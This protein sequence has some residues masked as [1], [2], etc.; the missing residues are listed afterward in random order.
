MAGFGD[1]VFP[2]CDIH[3]E[4]GLWTSSLG[5]QCNI[6]TVEQ[7]SSDRVPKPQ[8]NDALAQQLVAAAVAQRSP[9]LEPKQSLLKLGAGFGLCLALFALYMHSA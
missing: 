3:P 6:P 8:S 7:S 9:K 2:D 4:G 5:I 1:V